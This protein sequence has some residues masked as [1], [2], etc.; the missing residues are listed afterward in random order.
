MLY[1]SEK[2]F[3]KHYYY[4]ITWVLLYFRGGIELRIWKAIIKQRRILD[5]DGFKAEYSTDL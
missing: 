4:M 2:L 1:V 5:P 3:S